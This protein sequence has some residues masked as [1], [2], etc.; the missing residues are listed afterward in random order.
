MMNRTVNSFKEDYEELSTD[1]R[2]QSSLNPLNHPAVDDRSINDRVR[3]IRQ[4]YG[5]GV[6]Q[7]TEN[8]K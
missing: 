7:L 8:D 4:K 2:L 3:K 5:H 1:D 6:S